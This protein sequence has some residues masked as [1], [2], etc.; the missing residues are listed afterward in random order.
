MTEINSIWFILNE[1]LIGLTP[2]ERWDALTKYHSS[3]AASQRLLMISAAAV[4]AVIAAA[5]IW[6]WLNRQ[7]AAKTDNRRFD[8][9]AGKK[10]LTD[11]QKQLLL[12]VVRKAELKQKES[13][14]TLPDVFDQTVAGIIEQ[15]RQTKGISEALRLE[16]QFSSLREKLDFRQTAPDR[17][18]T[19][20]AQDSRQ[21]PVKKKLYIR[22]NPRMSGEL[23]ATVI[24]NSPA[25]ITIRFPEPAEIVFGQPWTCRYYT[26]G[27]VAEFQTVPVQCRGTVVVLRHSDKVRLVNRRRFVRVPV[28]KAAFVADCSLG[29]SPFVPRQMSRRKITA[30]DPV[31]GLSQTDFEPPQFVPATVT[32]LGGLG[33]RFETSLNVQAGDRIVLVLRLEETEMPMEYQQPPGGE[34]GI[35]GIARVVRAQRKESG[36]S[37]AAEYIYLEDEQLDVLVCAANAVLHQLNRGQHSAA[38]VLS[39]RR[40]PDAAAV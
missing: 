20:A 23:E 31:S 24:D 36:F 1:V 22:R 28:R 30:L 19:A 25:G 11:Q 26:G 8:D 3:P 35:A 27:F 9:Y 15:I 7:S 37:I 10:Q 2:L 18:M 39:S 5:V 33:V 34:K 32:E 12:R 17:Q 14:F 40:V 13:I 21:I 29:R 4:G 6:N 16:E 38:A